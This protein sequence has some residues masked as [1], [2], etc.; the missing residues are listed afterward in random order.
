MTETDYQKSVRKLVES[1]ESLPPPPER[2]INHTSWM[3]CIG[4]E[5]YGGAPA[6]HLGQLDRTL[7]GP[8]GGTPQPGTEWVDLEEA[9]R[10]AAERGDT[11]SF[12]GTRIYCP[13]CKDLLK[14]LKML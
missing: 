11:F 9:E 5:K 13:D 12:G 3:A 7:A 8:K 6:N 1:V 2:K 4:T 14:N 10:V